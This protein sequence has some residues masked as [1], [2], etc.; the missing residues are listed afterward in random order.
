MALHFSIY[1]HSPENGDRLRQAVASSGVGQLLET[2]DLAQLPGAGRNGTD[3]VLLEYQ[4]NNPS[5]IDGSKPP[6]RTLKIPRFLVFPGDLRRR[7]L[8]GPPPGGEGMS[9]PARGA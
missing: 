9:N 5:W 8:E 6:P 1:Y 3:V 4:E 7:A 2:E